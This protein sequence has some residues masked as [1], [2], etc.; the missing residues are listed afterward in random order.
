MALSDSNILSQE[1]R[2]MKFVTSLPDIKLYFG[3]MCARDSIS[4]AFNYNV[5]LFSDDHNIDI[6]SLL[7]NPATVHLK[8]GSGDW[9]YFNG[10]VSEF[11]FTGTQDRHAVYTATLRPWLWF[12]TR[13]SDC[14]IFQNKT[15]PDIVMEVFR[16]FGF[17][18]FRDDLSSSYRNWEYCVQYRES[19]FD[20]VS[21]LLEQEGIYYYFE[22]EDDKHTLVLAD[23][24]AAHCA[25]PDYAE[26]PYFPPDDDALREEDH[27][28]QWSVSKSVQ[29]GKVTLNDFNFQTPR[30]SL[31]VKSSIAREHLHADYEVYD[32]PGEYLTADEGNAYVRRHIEELQ[33]K[34]ES[35]KGSGNVANLVA[36]SLFTLTDFPRDDQN[37]EYLLVST[38]Y[39]LVN[40][41]YV[42]G[43]TGSSECHCSFTA[44]DSSEQYR[45]PQKTPKPIV[46]GP[47]TALV[48]GQGDIHTNQYACV[49]VQFHWDRYG[50]SDENSS[51][52]VRVSQ[53]WA[54]KDWGSMS[55]PH[56]GHEVIVEHLE[57]DPDRPIITGR[58]Y[59][60]ANMPPASLPD[61]KTQTTWQCHGGNYITFE[62]DLEIQALIQYSP[63]YNTQVTLGELTLVN[64]NSITIGGYTCCT[65]GNH[66]EKTKGDKDVS[67]WGHMKE[68]VKGNFIDTISGFQHSTNLGWTSNLIVGFK[69]EV[70]RGAVT[71]NT[72]GV[73][74]E[75]TA[76]RTF[77]HD[78][79]TKYELTGDEFKQKVPSVLQQIKIVKRLIT[80]NE[81]TEIG[82]SRV[83]KVGE[84][85][86]LEAKTSKTV[87]EKIEQKGETVCLSG[88]DL[89]SVISDIN[90]FRSKKSD[91]KA[92]EIKLKGKTSI[93]NGVMDILK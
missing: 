25:T 64:D 2:T 69:T 17:S 53:N 68:F 4:E 79:S 12:L 58:V 30:A 37:R 48:V 65:D 36:G 33:A 89:I 86:S 51:C 49:K 32:Y 21:R 35:A 52:W 38:N 41:S 54:G 90:E 60:D 27:I 77:N 72:K 63:T 3:R 83:V 80:D 92:D 55:L 76:G 56:V 9:R 73:K 31:E 23:S 67:V 84:N 42:S 13:T 43:S 61:K 40:N 57:G 1:S 5:E 87:A 45:A 50:E 16:D 18:D 85:H 39:D 14:R 47:Q 66:T 62:G 44:V 28:S 82:K 91:T 70:V 34:H 93:N 59:N 22:H 6:L 8:L 46:Q 78:K 26:V 81:K 74:T 24:L 71:T 15:V 29:S 11:S 19:A 10:I 7:G 75:I 20:F 88:A